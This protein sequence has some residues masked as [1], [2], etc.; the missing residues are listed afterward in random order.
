[1]QKTSAGHTA[2]VF[3]VLQWIYAGF[4]RGKPSI[5]LSDPESLGRM[6]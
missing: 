5:L 3:C 2:E 4:L 6:Q 1:M